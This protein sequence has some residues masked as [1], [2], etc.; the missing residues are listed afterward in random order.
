M[1]RD[2]YVFGDSHWRVF[3]PF[4]NHGAAT[5]NV[6]HEQDGVRTI[7]TIAN[8][9]SGATMYGLLTNGSR[10][11]ARARIL[12]TIDH[13]GGVDNVALTFGEVDARFHNG[14]Y[15]VGDRISYGRVY[16][17]IAR[18]KRFIEE[19]LKWSGRVRGNV[20]VYYGYRYPQGENTLLQPGQPIGPDGLRRAEALHSAFPMF[21]NSMIDSSIEKIHAITPW[22]GRPQENEVSAD[23]VHLVPEMIY[24]KVLAKML[25]IFEKQDIVRS[26]SELA[27]RET[28]L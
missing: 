9:L 28:P 18:Y 11:G 27:K 24:P 3:F 5:D 25:H 7:D 1:T 8:E 12:N 15:F 6:S 14:R 22:G 19:D 13:L 17:L 2:V 10:I 23:G 16:D 26:N 21:I 4:V 20:F